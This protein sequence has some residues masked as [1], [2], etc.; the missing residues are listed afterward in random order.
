MATTTLT[1]PTSRARGY[2]NHQLPRAELRVLHF[3]LVSPPPNT[4]N[5][6]LL[7]LLFLPIWNDDIKRALRTPHFFVLFFGKTVSL[8]LLGAWASA[9]DIIIM[10]AGTGIGWGV[11]GGHGRT[12]K[13]GGK[14]LGGFGKLLIG[15]VF[16]CSRS[17]LYQHSHVLPQLD[18]TSTSSAST[19]L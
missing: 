3:G 13:E 9:S 17:T 1:Q 12:W 8:S 15:K 19:T 4:F 14:Y 2:L 18:T 10:V 7:S 5:Q 16:F 11:M 6:R